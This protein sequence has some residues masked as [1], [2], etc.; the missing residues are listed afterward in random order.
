[1]IK[2]TFFSL[3]SVVP[4]GVDVPGGDRST[5]MNRRCGSVSNRVEII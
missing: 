3:M 4:I 1:M 5:Q 2:M